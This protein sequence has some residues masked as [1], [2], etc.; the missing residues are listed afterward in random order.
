MVDPRHE[1]LAKREGDDQ[2][3]RV[4]SVLEIPCEC[5]RSG[6]GEVIALPWCVYEE[7]QRE[8]LVPGH[9]LPGIRGALS[10][11]DSFVVVAKEEPESQ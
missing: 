9:E 4:G 11:Y 7:A 6:C 8:P 5:G 2:L 10:R 1:R 3:A